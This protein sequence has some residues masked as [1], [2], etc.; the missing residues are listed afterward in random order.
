MLQIQAGLDDLGA[1]RN[2]EKGSWAM[3]G[4]GNGS[5]G[6][7]SHPNPTGILGSNGRGALESLESLPVLFPM[8]LDHERRGLDIWNVSLWKRLFQPCPH[9]QR[10]WKSLWMRPLGTGISAGDGWTP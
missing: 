9:S 5:P 7:S 2:K 3:A 10:D 4:I 8:D 1:T 6:R